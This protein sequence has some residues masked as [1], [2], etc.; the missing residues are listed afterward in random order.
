MSTPPP[1]FL[2]RILTRIKPRLSM[3]WPILNFIR[4]IS[5]GD[6]K[7][8]SN[9]KLL[10]RI[11]CRFLKLRNPVR[12]KYTI[13]DNMTQLKE[14]GRK[15]MGPK[16]MEDTCIQQW[17]KLWSAYWSIDPVPIK[18][19]KIINV[20]PN[21]CPRPQ[22]TMV[23]IFLFQFRIEGGIMMFKLVLLAPVFLILGSD[24]ISLQEVP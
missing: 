4:K 16:D 11:P 10:K 19:W 2:S 24:W 14:I 9:K 22:V 5:K 7:I 20:V 8:E 17:K 1:T 18:E 13:R 23:Y 3:M 12:L 21:N 6:R 15:S